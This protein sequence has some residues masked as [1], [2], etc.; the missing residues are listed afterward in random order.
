MKILIFGATGMVGQGVLREAH[1]AGDVSAL[2]IVGRSPSGTRHPKLSE[3]VHA[4]LLDLSPVAGQLTGFD[5][6]FFC[7]GAS[8]VGVDEATYTRINYDIPVAIGQCLASLNPGMT[9][10]YVSGAGTGSRPQIMWARVKRRTEEALATMPFKA[11]YMFRPG[12]IQP[13]NGARSK[14]ALYHA[15][16]VITSPLLSAARHFF[17][18]YVLSTQEIGDAMLIAIRRGAPQCILEAAD[19]RALLQT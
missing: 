15:F 19:I 4:N 10:I 9:F 17:P 6:C 1:A 18:D 7:L 2:T 13:L 5:G 8:S 12:V 14:T 16:Y 11:A 3:I